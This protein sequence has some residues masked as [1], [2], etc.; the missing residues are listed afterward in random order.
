MLQ[1][2]CHFTR[3]IKKLKEYVDHKRLLKIVNDRELGE[4]DNPSILNFK[5]KTLRWRFKV[6]LLPGKDHHEAYAMSRYPIKTSKE[7]AWPTMRSAT[8]HGNP[9]TK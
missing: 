4:I 8:P 2:S 3:G 9:A 1:K 7:E 6:V 5:E